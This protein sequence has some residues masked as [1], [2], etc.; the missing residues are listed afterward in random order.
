M[1]P[2]SAVYRGESGRDNANWIEFTALDKYKLQ[3]VTPTPI[4][5]IAAGSIA[6]AMGY[7]PEAVAAYGD[8]EDWRHAI[9][10]GPWML[11]DFVPDSSSTYK[12]NP[13][14]WQKDPLR[15]EYSM[16]YMDGYRVIVIPDTATA[17]SAIATHKILT[18]GT[19][20]EK[21]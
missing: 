19:D 21:G 1:S 11:T 2:R 16:P 17:M 14:Y 8:L 20:F 10:T 3:V 15:P 18:Y 7:P 12:K 13:S 5:S 4:L 9:G 6:Y